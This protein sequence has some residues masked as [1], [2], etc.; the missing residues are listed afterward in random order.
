MPYASKQN[1]IDRFSEE[2]LIQLTDR[3]EPYTQEIIDAVLNQALEDADAMINTYLAKRY[4][5][6]LASI[7]AV[8]PRH[9]AV[10]AYYDLHRGHHPEEVRTNYEDTLSFLD[11][12]SRGLVVLDAQGTEP[13]S[14]PADARVEG[15]DRMFS[16]DSL[17]GF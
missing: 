15:P 5:L 11:K 4:D 17:K 14:A 3:V 16:R 2:S 9:A 7:P 13:S 12:V 1:M 10:I 8:L 6:P